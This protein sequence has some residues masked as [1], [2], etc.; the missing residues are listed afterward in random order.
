MQIAK[1]HM[2]TISGLTVKQK[3]LLTVMW[4]IDSTDKVQEFIRTLPAADAR[5]AHCLLQ[6]AI[7]ESI[8]Q[9]DGLE[10]Y[11]SLAKDCISRCSSK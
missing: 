2:I 11:E 9:Q 5:D 7:W 6:M 4:D 10:S 1:E 8:E 3:A